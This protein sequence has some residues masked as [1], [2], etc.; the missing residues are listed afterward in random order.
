MIVI[1]TGTAQSSAKKKKKKKTA[2]GGGGGGGGEGFVYDIDTCMAPCIQIPRAGH[3]D[4]TG[5]MY[6]SFVI[7]H[8]YMCHT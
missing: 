2:W 7:M 1:I 4:P 3:W 6:T 8:S 5:L